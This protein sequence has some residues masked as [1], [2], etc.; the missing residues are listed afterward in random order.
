VREHGREISLLEK[1]AHEATKHRRHEEQQWTAAE[2][3]GR[4]LIL[5]EEKALKKDL[6][7]QTLGSFKDVGVSVLKDVKKQS[8]K[9]PH[10]KKRRQ[11]DFQGTQAARRRPGWK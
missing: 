3:S 8:Q 2:T 11:N 5:R 10:D 4:W 9:Q 6:L 7:L 1:A